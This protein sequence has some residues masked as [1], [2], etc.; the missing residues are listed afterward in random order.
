M[1]KRLGYIDADL[2]ELRHLGRKNPCGAWA[3]DTTRLYMTPAPKLTCCMP[4]DH[5]YEY[6]V[7]HIDI[8]NNKVWRNGLLDYLWVKDKTVAQPKGEAK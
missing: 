5:E 2:S 7:P 8:E 4:Y 3:I 1:N 6:G